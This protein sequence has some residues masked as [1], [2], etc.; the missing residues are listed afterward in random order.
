MV[1]LGLARGGVPVAY[2]VARALRAPLDVFSVRK[3]RAPGYPELALGAIAANG[4][5]FINWDIVTSLALDDAALES[6]VGREA[7]ELSRNESAYRPFERR[8]PLNNR[9]VLLIDDGLATGSSMSAAI[10]A[11]REELP[12]RVVV[13]VPVAPPARCSALRKLADDV[14][15]AQTPERFY[16]VGTWYDDFTQTSDQE[17]REILE[18]ASSDRSR[19]HLG[20]VSGPRV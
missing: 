15:C 10:E 20:T 7:A 5:R 18:E 14:I 4:V 17:V 2:E 8:Q 1:V 6:I 11:V 12:S 13:G 9:I 19:W 16:S 3:L